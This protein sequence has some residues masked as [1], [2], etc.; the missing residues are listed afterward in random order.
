MEQR[1]S[2]T[3]SMKDVAFGVKDA[4]FRDFVFLIPRKVLEF[5]H[6]T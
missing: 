6:V 3:T 5:V 2:L 4:A 1:T